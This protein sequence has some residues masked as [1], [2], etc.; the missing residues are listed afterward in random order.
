MWAFPTK[1]SVWFANIYLTINI[2]QFT[3]VSGPPFS[4]R[5]SSP[6]TRPALLPLSS[7][8][9]DRRPLPAPLLTVWPQLCVR[10]PIIMAASSFLQSW[11]LWFQHFLRVPLNV[12]VGRINSMINV[13][14]IFVLPLDVPPTQEVVRGWVGIRQGLLA[15]RICPP[16]EVSGVC[17][18]PK[19]ASENFLRDGISW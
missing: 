5:F 7:H 13:L 8:R 16:P 19:L 12:W 11:T 6:A 14:L 2:H 18:E 1:Y 9:R 10:T 15:D 17:V 3:D 4:L